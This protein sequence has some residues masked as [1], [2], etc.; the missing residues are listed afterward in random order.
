MTGPDPDSIH[1]PDDPYYALLDSGSNLCLLPRF[2]VDALLWQ[3]PFPHQWLSTGV[4]SVPCLDME[5]TFQIEFAFGSNIIRIP[6]HKFIRRVDPPVSPELCILNIGY[7]PKTPGGV[8][9]VILGSMS[10]IVSCY[11]L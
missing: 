1:F 9:W 8:E 2:L 4:I 11:L 3:L 6:L 5:D 7:A 10:D